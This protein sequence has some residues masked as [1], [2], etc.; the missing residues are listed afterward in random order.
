MTIR[1]LDERIPVC[2]DQVV[3]DARFSAGGTASS[4]RDQRPQARLLEE[5]RRRAEELLRA[6]GIFVL[7]G[8]PEW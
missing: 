4:S 1:L 3:G 2:G 7:V 8:A 6:A 5:L